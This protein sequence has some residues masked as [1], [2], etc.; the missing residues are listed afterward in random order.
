MLLVGRPVLASRADWPV[1][2]FDLIFEFVV[3]HYEHAYRYLACRFGEFQEQVFCTKVAAL[4][5]VSFW[6]VAKLLI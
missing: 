1:S 5:L 4:R 3:A 2:L 6:R